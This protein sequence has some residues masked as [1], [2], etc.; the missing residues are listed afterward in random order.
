MIATYIGQPLGLFSASIITA[1]NMVP[2][3][4]KESKPRRACER[5]PE[6]RVTKQEEL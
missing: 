2:S 3:K 5:E 4:G 6:E 1:K